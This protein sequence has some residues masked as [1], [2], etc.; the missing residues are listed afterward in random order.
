MQ[1]KS[2]PGTSLIPNIVGLVQSDDLNNVLSWRGDC[3]LLPDATRYF[4]Q[5]MTI[6]AIGRA[7]R[8]PPIAV[9]LAF[10]PHTISRDSRWSAQ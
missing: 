3:G 5:F 8:N 1:R 4:A 7:E 2:L 9:R 10:F 6:T